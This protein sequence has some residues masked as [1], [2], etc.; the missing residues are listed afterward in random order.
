V[1]GSF[2][3]LF[4]RLPSEQIGT[5]YSNRS[6]LPIPTDRHFLFQEIGNR[7]PSNPVKF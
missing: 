4:Q 2:A 5:S 6:T 7:F 3:L 1:R